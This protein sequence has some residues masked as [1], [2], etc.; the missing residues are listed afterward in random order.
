[1]PHYNDTQRTL[2]PGITLSKPNR[3]IR[4]TEKRRD[5]VRKTK[6]VKLVRRYKQICAP[7]T[8]YKSF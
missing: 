3:S 6:F 8:P 2:T 1:M 5:D 7:I 4:F